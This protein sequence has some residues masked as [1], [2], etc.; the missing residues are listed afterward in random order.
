MSKNYNSIIAYF[1]RF[2]KYYRGDVG[3]SRVF[4]SS[5]LICGG[6]AK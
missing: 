5:R 3:I 4:S 2:V 1:M 6:G